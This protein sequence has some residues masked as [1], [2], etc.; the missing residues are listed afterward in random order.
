MENKDFRAMVNGEVKS[1]VSGAASDPL[2]VAELGEAERVASASAPRRLRS[3][4]RAL[5]AL[6]CLLRRIALSAREPLPAQIKLAWWR[7]ACAHLP[8]GDDHPVLGALAATWRGDPGLLVALVDAW[9]EVAVGE[10]AV[11]AVAERLAAHRTDALAACAREG[12][13]SGRA[14]V[15]CWTLTMLADRARSAEEREG[16]LAA[17]RDTALPKLPRSWRPVSLLAGLARRASLRGHGELLGDRWSPLAAMRLG[18]F[19][20]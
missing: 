2:V 5:L 8:A 15:T 18:I 3:G 12:A 11:S 6:D 13:G 1:P 4:Y 20:R 9:E 17:A 14:A 16:M 7:E 19:G 10:A